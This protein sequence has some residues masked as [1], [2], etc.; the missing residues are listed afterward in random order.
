MGTA[1]WSSLVFAIYLWFQSHDFSISPA[2]TVL[3][4]LSVWTWNALYPSKFVLVHVRGGYLGRAVPTE[5]E[6]LL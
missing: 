1:P 4:A 5:A 6:E 3:V 2:P